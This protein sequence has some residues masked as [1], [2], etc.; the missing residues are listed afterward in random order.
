M[1]G[2]KMKKMIDIFEVRHAVKGG[3]L[4]LYIQIGFDRDR[5]IMLRDVESGEVVSLAVIG[6]EVFDD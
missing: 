1:I 3:Q 2:A 4:E 6:S 5:W